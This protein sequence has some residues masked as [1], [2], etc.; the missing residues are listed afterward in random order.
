MGLQQPNRELCHGWAVAGEALLTCS[1]GLA[2][3]VLKR[4]FQSSTSWLSM[5]PEEVGWGAVWE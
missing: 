2:S 1:D 5:G 3:T 4:C